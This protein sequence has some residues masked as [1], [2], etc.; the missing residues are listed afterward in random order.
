MLLRSPQSP[1]PESNPA[2]T[3]IPAGSPNSKS[4]GKGSVLSCVL[5]TLCPT[6]PRHVPRGERLRGRVGCARRQTDAE[7]PIAR[8]ANQR[9]AGHANDGGMPM[10]DNSLNKTL[11]IMGYDTGPGNDH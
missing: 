5:S 9:S 7:A 8:D 3:R 4:R 6:M 11:R 2:L 10:S 1:R